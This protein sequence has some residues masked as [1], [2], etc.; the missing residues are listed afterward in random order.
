MS[1]WKSLIAAR[2]DARRQH[3]QLIKERIAIYMRNRADFADGIDRLQEML[4]TLE[5]V[6]PAFEDSR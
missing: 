5:D 6:R 1:D 2:D 3:M 4:R